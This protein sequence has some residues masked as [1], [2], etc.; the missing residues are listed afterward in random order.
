LQSKIKT[1]QV[2]LANKAEVKIMTAKKQ[3]N[4]LARFQ[5][6]GWKVGNAKNFLQLSEEEPLKPPMPHLCAAQSS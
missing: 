2:D 3:A 6:A 4:K 5:A 1:L